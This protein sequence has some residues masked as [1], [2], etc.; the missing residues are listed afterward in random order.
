MPLG[1]T[2]EPEEYEAAAAHDADGQQ[3]DG[4]YQQEAQ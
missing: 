1:E 2:Q 4:A 3:D